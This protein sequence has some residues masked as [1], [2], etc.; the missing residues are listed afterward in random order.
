MLGFAALGKLPLGASGASGAIELLV[1]ESGSASDSRTVAATYSVGQS[2]SGSA[3]ESYPAGVGVS[4]AETGSAADHPG[5]PLSLTASDSLSVSVSATS[6]VASSAAT[7]A[8]YASAADSPTTSWTATDVFS[9]AVQAA[10]RGDVVPGCYGVEFDFGSGPVSVWQ[11]IGP[12]DASAFGG[13]TFQGIGNFGKIGSIQLGAVGQTD[14]V[15][16]EL[17]GL[18]ATFFALAQTQQTQVRGRLA[19]LYLLFFSPT[20]SLLACG[21]RRTYRMDKITTRVNAAS[22]PPTM[23]CQL[24]CEPILAPK[25]HAPWSF[26]TDADQRGRFG[27]DR[28]LERTQL[29]T[30]RQTVVW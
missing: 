23:I 4:I 7:I 20:W 9:A 1:S 8:E 28:G 24:S 10:L 15:N 17:S 2:D 27:G 12:L 11:G 29:L 22:D 14:G 5:A 19:K 30:N 6:A 13:P 3:S 16:F 18:D 25:N 26:L 21:V